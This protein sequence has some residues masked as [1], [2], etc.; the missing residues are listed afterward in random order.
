MR[1]LNQRVTQA[2]VSVEGEKV[3]A[4]GRGLAVLLGV[5]RGDVAEDAERLARKTAEMRIFPD[6]TGRFNLSLLDIGGEALVVSQ[7]TLLADT[8]RGRR[9]D[10]MA[11]APPEEAETLVERYVSV[12]RQMGVPVSTGRFGAHMLVEIHN[13]GPVT[14]LLDTADLD[15]PRRA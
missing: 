12:L 8:R 15:R 14:I 2:C 10:F 11:A 5:A 7:F 4:V 13:D 1:A 6:A 9:P 3:G